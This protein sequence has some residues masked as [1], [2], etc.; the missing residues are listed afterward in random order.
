MD[1]ELNAAIA[2]LERTPTVLNAYLKDLPRD[3]THQNE[4]EDTWSPFDVIGHL[5]HGEKTDWLVRT[6]QILDINSDKEFAPFDRFAQFEISRGKTLNQLLEQF[7]KSRTENLVELQSLPLTEENLNKEGIHPEFGRV[8]I[9]ELLATWT[10]HDL[11][12]IS[13]ISRVMAFQ[14]KEAVGP[15]VKYLKILND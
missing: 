9:R 1:F 8:S 4:G 11:G 13:Q 5:I 3:W 15:W 14:H 2:L 10:V 6:K 12:H 7:E